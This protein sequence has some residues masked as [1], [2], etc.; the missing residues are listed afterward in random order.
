MEV[1]CE[2][3]NSSRLISIT[4]RERERTREPTIPHDEDEEKEI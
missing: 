2:H 1:A 3:S 4:K